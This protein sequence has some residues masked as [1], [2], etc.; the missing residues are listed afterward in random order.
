MDWGLMLECGMQGGCLSNEVN[1]E[2][3]VAKNQHLFILETSFS[4]MPNVC[5]RMHKPPY[6]ADIDLFN[7]ITR[8]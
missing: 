4:A 8:A 3:S 2:Y 6:K 1:S 5:W 7:V